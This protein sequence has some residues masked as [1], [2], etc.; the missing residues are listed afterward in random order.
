MAN[1]SNRRKW[2]L[3]P[4]L[5]VGFIL[6]LLMYTSHAATL[7][8]IRVGEYAGFTRIVFELDAL[9]K[10]VKIEPQSAGR[11]TVEFANTNAD[12][13]RKIPVE[14]SPHLRN[15]QIWEKGAE[16]TAILAFSF[17][18]Y[19]QKSFSLNNPPR[20][21][22][23]VHPLPNTRKTAGA[24]PSEK[25]RSD[26]SEIE[27]GR[28]L[29]GSRNS[30]HQ[31]ASH[32]ESASRA[33]APHTGENVN[34]PVP[35]DQNDHGSTGEAS[36]SEAHSTTGG[37]MQPSG[38]VHQTPHIAKNSAKPGGS[39]VKQPRNAV[40]PSAKRPSRLQYFLVIFLVFITIT[41]L[42]L[43]LL[44]LLVKHAWI[45]NRSRSTAVKKPG[46]RDKPKSENEGKSQQP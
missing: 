31:D 28:L 6:T 27:G 19:G 33:L 45:G 24:S 34:S 39:S 41:I 25:N 36:G 42:V 16:L 40:Q 30:P 22:V 7:K 26:E 46:S 15:V 5:S 17:K 44:M 9:P 43:L 18:N 4:F 21:V 32:R 2:V 10:P 20:L 8:D 13:I 3:S 11:L 35:D 37:E 38:A 29:Q 23:D 1:I 12:L 14:R